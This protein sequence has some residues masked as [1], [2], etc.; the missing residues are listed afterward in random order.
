MPVSLTFINWN[1]TDSLK[2]FLKR[3]MTSG[4]GRPSWDR[5]HFL[6][7]GFSTPSTETYKVNNLQ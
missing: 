1:I 7:V 4:Q 3:H 2:L 5:H 6:A